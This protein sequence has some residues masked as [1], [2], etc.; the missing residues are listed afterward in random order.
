[1]NHLFVEIA[2]IIDE[3]E[4]AFGDFGARGFSKILAEWIKAKVSEELDR[5]VEDSEI[6]MALLLLA[7]KREMTEIENS[8]CSELKDF[9]K[10]LKEI[11]F[12]RF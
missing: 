11:D 4:T 9:F 10:L 1:M 8:V 7:A 2:G 3:V 6:V 5:G 12:F